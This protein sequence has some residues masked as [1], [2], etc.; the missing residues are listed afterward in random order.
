MAQTGTARQSL[1]PRQLYTFITCFLAWTLDA[2]DFFIL[3]FCLKTIAADFQVTPTTVTK[4]LFWTLA[5]RP[6]GA[7]LFGMLAER[8][9][10]KRALILNVLCFTTFGVAS[11]FAPSFAT[12]LLLRALFGVAM[13]GE[14]G[15]GAALALETL[16]ASGRGFFSGLLQEGY[17][18]GH[19]VA[20]ALFGLVFSHLHG[21]GY[22]TNWRV[23]FCLSALP[24][25]LVV[26]L[27]VGV[28]ESPVWLAAR[29]GAGEIAAAGG[30]ESRWA[31][32][33]R[34]IPL[35]LMLI[36]LMTSFASFSH[37]TQDLYPTF[38][39]RDHRLSA[40]TTS[41]VAIAGDVG[42][43]LGGITFGALSERWGRRRAITTAALLAIPMIPLWAWSHTAVLL[44]CGGL[45][46]QFMVQ[47]AWGV[48]PAYLNEM[49]PGPL[50][51]IIPGLTYQL[52]NLIASWNSH[53]Q[54]S[55]ASRFY[56]GRLAPVLGWTVLLVAVF[57]AIV[58]A[59][60]REKRGTDF[61]GV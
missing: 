28:A 29:Q 37:G 48:V 43:L 32:L 33:R 17:V 38:L 24:S 50:R 18:T 46:M 47:G 10:R 3:T 8:M 52:G 7:L 60:A 44:A 26:G 20:A 34:H 39:Q 5:M 53:V 15:V 54:E 11:A 23:M 1:S 59:T 4:A 27:L 41:W 21:T 61:L 57:M 14:W 49:S 58:A 22:A 31:L 9:G 45:L 12:F 40:G 13:G 36:L 25:L 6:V 16:P 2:A 35:L 51:A 42:A 56:G 55:A 19:L 30:G